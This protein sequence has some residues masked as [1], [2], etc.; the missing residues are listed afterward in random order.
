MHLAPSSMQNPAVH[1]QV[2]V[3][4]RDETIKESEVNCPTDEAWTVDISEETKKQLRQLIRA[5]QVKWDQDLNPIMPRPQDR[6]V[7]RKPNK[8][9]SWKNKKPAKPTEMSEVQEQMQDTKEHAQSVPLPPILLDFLT[10]DVLT[11][12]MSPKFEKGE[13]SSTPHEED[14]DSD[15]GTCNV[16]VY[17]GSSSSDSDEEAVYVKTRNLEC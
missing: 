1:E 14:D 6:V 2:N 13:S 7:H 5:P 15:H 11:A 17:R 16:V 3:V 4:S 8:N 12:M 9:G 10:E